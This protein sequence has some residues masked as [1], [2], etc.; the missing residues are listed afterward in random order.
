MRPA[1]VDLRD[2]IAQLTGVLNRMLASL[3][4]SRASERRFLADASH[5]LRT[6]VTTLLGNVEYAARH[7]ADAE[8]LDDL[9]RDAARLAR[10][11][12]NLLALERE[13]GPEPEREPV[14]LDELVAA[15]VRDHEHESAR[16]RL[17][18]LEPARVYG[19]QEALRRVIAN[20]I[21]NALVHG[22]PG[23]RVDVAVHSADG[24]ARL[25]VE[26]RRTGSRSGPTRA[27]VRA[28]LARA[29]C[30]RAPRLGTRLVNRRRDRRTPRRSDR[31][32][33]IAVHNRAANRIIAGALSDNLR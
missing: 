2:E 18:V 7:G 8:V 1:G 15:T 10:L 25:T 11:V 32:R 24:H 27:A 17:G 5:E 20:L 4:R 21:D 23:G 28:L 19:D 26:R 31:R 16:I 9:Q 22:P 12:D 33:R 13:G 30:R 3:E 14:E 29:G 6:P